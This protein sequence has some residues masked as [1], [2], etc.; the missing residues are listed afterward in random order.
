MPTDEQLWARGRIVVS[1]CSLCGSD[2]ESTEHLF[3]RC[4]FARA[5]WSWFGNILDCSVDCSSIQSILTLCK[6]NWSS[7][8]GDI[9]VAGIINI[10]WTIWHCRNK[11]KFDN[12][13]IPISSALNLIIASVSLAGKFSSGT[14]SNSIFDFKLLKQFSVEGHPRHAPSIKQVSRHPPLCN[15]VKCNTDGAA[16][17]SPGYTSCGGIFRAKSAAILGCFAAN[18]GITNAL[19]AELIGAMFAIELVD[20]KGWQKIV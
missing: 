10:F 8:I 16:K 4:N 2:A 12:K 19:H 6:Q 14:M 17:G 15:W 5:L 18:L 13:V 7:Q 9:I 11:I 3:F 1:I 20:Q